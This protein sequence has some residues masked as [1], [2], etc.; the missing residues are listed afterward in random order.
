[1]T[2]ETALIVAINVGRNAIR[3]GDYCWRQ[4]QD[5]MLVYQWKVASY[6]YL[7]G[8]Q[9]IYHNK[10]GEKLPEPKYEYGFDNIP[11]DGVDPLY[12]SLYR[13]HLLPGTITINETKTSGDELVRV[14][15]SLFKDPSTRAYEECF[16]FLAEVLSNSVYYDANV[17]TRVL[18]DY[19]I[20]ESTCIRF[21]MD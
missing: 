1:M 6:S 7:M 14:Y 21:T 5:S 8:F 20:D 2:N 10:N 19:I 4:T 12:D 11:S 18:R 13:L 3:M 17:F 15:Q 9:V 16:N